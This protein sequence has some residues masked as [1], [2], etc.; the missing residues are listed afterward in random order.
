MNLPQVYMCSPSWTFLPPPFYDFLI[1]AHIHLGLI[2]L[3]KF[4]LIYYD[5]IRACVISRFSR[6]RLFATLWTTACQARLST[7]FSRED[8]WSR[9]SF[10][11]P[12]DLPNWG[13]QPPSLLRLLHCGRVL[14]CWATREAHSNSRA[15]NSLT[16]RNITLCIFTERNNLIR[17]SMKRISA[18]NITTES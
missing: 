4:N 1:K 6:V 8:Y 15:Q 10:P 11:P 14:Y 17:Y 18:F 13:I 3:L 5:N 9:L 7:G 2:N 12:G 16:E